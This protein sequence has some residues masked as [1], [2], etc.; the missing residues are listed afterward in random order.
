MFYS[1][2]SRL[3][4]T[5][6]LLQTEGGTGGLGKEQLWSW[7]KVIF[8]AQDFFFLV[9]CFFFF[10]WFCFHFITINSSLGKLVFVLENKTKTKQSFYSIIC[11]PD[12]I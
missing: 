9:S 10:F 1:S 5:G 6:C 11:K 12:L 8:I 4:Y 2:V 3:S 7:F